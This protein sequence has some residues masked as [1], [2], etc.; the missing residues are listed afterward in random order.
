VDG[1]ALARAA[2]W[3][4]DRIDPITGRLGYRR[5]GKD[6]TVLAGADDALGSSSTLTG[7]ALLASSYSREPLARFG[8]KE[9]MSSR[10]A[11]L[12]LHPPKYIEGGNDYFDTYA[13]SAALFRFDGPEGPRWKAW[14]EDLKNLLVPHQMTGK[15]GC[16]D[17]SWDPTDRWSVA[18]GRV[19]ATAMNALNLEFYYRYANVMFGASRK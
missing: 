15:D 6:G 5:P 4:D 11:A 18:G 9:W 12:I 8:N 14:N 13:V 3:L 1:A 10:A 2:R 7:L 17:G 19:Y 16:A